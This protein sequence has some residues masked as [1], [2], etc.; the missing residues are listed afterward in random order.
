MIAETRQNKARR[1]ADR[2]LSC[3]IYSGWAQ[4]R[5]DATGFVWSPAHRLRVGAGLRVVVW[6]GG[7]RSWTPAFICR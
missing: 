7:W 4:R 5:A 6:V 2:L 3:D 1:S